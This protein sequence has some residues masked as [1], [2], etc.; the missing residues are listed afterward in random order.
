MKWVKIQQLSK[1]AKGLSYVWAKHSLNYFDY[2]YG[3]D[4]RGIEV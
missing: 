3:M 1:Y 2:C 4:V